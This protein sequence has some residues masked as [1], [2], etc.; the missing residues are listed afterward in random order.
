M[1][2]PRRRW[3][4]LG[5][6]LGLLLAP[7]LGWAAYAG[8]T[9]LRFGPTNTT[10]P[11]DPLMRRHM[12]RWDIAEAHRTPVDAPAALVYDAARAMDLHESRV[13]HAIFGS[14]ERLL[15]ASTVPRP[16]PL[17]LL[18]ELRSLG[19][20]VLDEVPGRQVVLG[21]V[22][23]PWEA[24]V[25]FRALPPETFAAFDSAGWVKI[26]VTLAADST[27]PRTS[28]FRTETR[29]LATD[30]ASRAR[31]RRYWAVFSP[32]ILLIRSRALALVRDRAERA[33]DSSEV[34]PRSTLPRTSARP[35]P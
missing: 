4:L 17:P 3:L 34:T 8:A 9:W 35:S 13:V 22:T 31:F 20:G 29:A 24:N 26:V 10:A 30:A 28:T 14:R 21:A 33:A 19:W 2:T 23:R 11:G 27:G 18:D 25:V 12:P 6:P 15:G 32:G 7:V 1:R 5:I 16:T